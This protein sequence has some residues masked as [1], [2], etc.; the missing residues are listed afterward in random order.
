M[1]FRRVG[2]S[3]LTVS[4]IG[5][6]S[7]NFGP[8][9]D[10]E[11]SRDIVHRALDAGITFFDTADI[12]GQSEEYLGE[13]LGGRRDEVVLAT[14]FGIGVRRFGND[15]GPDWDARGARRYVRIAVESSLR[16]LKT[17]WIDLYQ[18]HRPDPLTPIEET[19]STLDDLVHEGKIRYVGHS[20]FAAWQVADADWTARAG[21]LVRP[22]SSQNL[23]NLLDRTAERELAPLADHYG[24]SVIPHTPLAG[25]LLTGKYRRGEPTPAGRLAGQHERITAAQYDVLEALEAFAAQRDITMTDAAIGYLLAQPFVPSVIAGVSSVAQLDANLAA[26]SWTPTEEDLGELS[27]IADAWS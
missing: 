11:T 8:R 13:I 27:A 1:E 14:K 9:T 5:I 10:L 22:V 3:G 25:G 4:R 20:N 7:N 23:Y 26:A 15:N 16:R 17:D 21:G 12:Y 24:I 19:L 2:R 6:G 18:Y